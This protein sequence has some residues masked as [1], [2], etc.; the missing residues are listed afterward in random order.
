MHR[1]WGFI[2]G[3]IAVVLFLLA[4]AARPGGETALLTFRR[5]LLTFLAQ[6]CS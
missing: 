5:G 6:H 3:D 1:N 2:L 4:L